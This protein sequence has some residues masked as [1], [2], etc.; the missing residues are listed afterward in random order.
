MSLY[1]L[2]MRHVLTSY[3]NV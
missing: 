1:E 3:T 2:H